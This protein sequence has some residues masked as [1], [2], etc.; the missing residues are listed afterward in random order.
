MTDSAEQK[1]EPILDFEGKRY[2]ITSLP[3]EAQKLIT[4]MR[5]ADAQ[6]RFQNDTLKILSVGRQSMGLKLK[7]LLKDQSPV[8]DN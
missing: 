1:K 6:I 4:G 3:E 7:D 2:V 5:V 8:E